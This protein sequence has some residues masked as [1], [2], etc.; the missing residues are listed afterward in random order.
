MCMRIASIVIDKNVVTQ[1]GFTQIY[2]NEN[3]LKVA[4]LTID[5]ST[6]IVDMCYHASACYVQCLSIGPIFRV[7]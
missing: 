6:S 5:N 4:S 3:N 2:T 1:L 7:C